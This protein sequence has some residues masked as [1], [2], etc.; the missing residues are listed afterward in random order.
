MTLIKEIFANF[1]KEM[2]IKINVVNASADELIQRI[3]SEGDQTQL[4]YSL[5][6]MQVGL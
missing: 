3:E 1:E 4:I 5:Q 6:L 2:G